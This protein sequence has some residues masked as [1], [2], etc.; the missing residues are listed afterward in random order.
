MNTQF[1][2]LWGNALLN[3]SA[4]QKQVESFVNLMKIGNFNDMGKVSGQYNF[5]DAVSKQISDTLNTTFNTTAD[6]KQKQSEF[7][8]S[9]LN[10]GGFE[11]MAKMFGQYDFNNTTPETTSDS[12]N[13]LESIT[14]FLQQMF[15]QYLDMMGVVAK[16]DHLKLN[17]KYEVLKSKFSNHK[18]AGS[19]KDGATG[20]LGNVVE[21]F[22]NLIKK[23]SEQFQGLMKLSDGYFSDMSSGSQ[24]TK[25]AT[26]KSKK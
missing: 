18:N 17:A 15:N 6:M 19:L 5:K 3:M 23:Q 7:F 10:V 20:N 4:G 8:D 2:D 14:N 1:L 12:T 16:K 22:E 26:K 25:S 11:E 21:N 9:V 24:K 13:G